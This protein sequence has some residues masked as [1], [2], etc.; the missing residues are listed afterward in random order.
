MAGTDTGHVIPLG[1]PELDDV[2]PGSVPVALPSHA[3]T[4]NLDNY[5]AVAAKLAKS[6]TPR[7]RPGRGRLAVARVSR[8]TRSRNTTDDIVARFMH[9]KGEDPQT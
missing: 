2:T 3:A 6:T 1:A 9:M 5:R 4:P 8:T 7:V